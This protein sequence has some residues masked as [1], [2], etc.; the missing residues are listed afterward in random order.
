MRVVTHRNVGTNYISIEK[1]REGFLDL[2][3]QLRSLSFH[4]SKI[5]SSYSKPQQQQQ[6]GGE[7][8]RERGRGTTPTATTTYPQ[9]E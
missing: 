9:P 5:A 8:D 3:T 2:S 4:K 7:R 6:Q 1:K